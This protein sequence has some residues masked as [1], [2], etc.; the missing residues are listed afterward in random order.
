VCVKRHTAAVGAVGSALA[1]NEEVPDERNRSSTRSNTRRHSWLAAITQ[2]YWGGL[3]ATDAVV[4]RLFPFLW[5]PR[6]MSTTQFSLMLS[7]NIGAGILVGEYLGGFLSDRFGRKKILVASAI[8]D[9]AFLWPLGYTNSFGWLLLWNFL[10][11]TG[12]GFMLASNAV[13]LH[14]IAP[15]N[16]R[17]RIAMR[18][19]LL[20]AVVI[21]VPAV[22]AYF[23][24]PS[25]YRWY[26]WGLVAI[27][28][29]ILTP[30][31]IFGLPE[32]P[33]WLEGKGR[34]AEADRI[35]SRWEAEI[36][37]LRGPLPPPDAQAHP[38]VETEQ[39]PA[40]ELVSPRYRRR[41][42]LLLAVWLLAYPGL[43]Y[44]ATAYTP[45]YLVEHGWTSHQIFLWGGSGSIIGVPVIIAVFYLCS[46]F[47]E[48]YERK[49]IVTIAGIAFAAALLLLLAFD[50]TKAAVS[51]L[52]LIAGAFGTLWLFN[53]Y[54][55]TAAAYP[56]RLRSVGTGWTDGVGHLGVFLGPPLIGVL[57]TS[58]AP[59]N[60]GWILWCALPCALLPSLIV[61]VFGMRQRNAVLEQIST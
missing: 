8:L 11:A 48:R 30:L 33:R 32:S 4:A 21:A 39:V 45:T 46:L 6:G 9:A 47:G 42:I 12:M 36:T 51:V 20:T 28:I 40:K 27:M 50:G 16:F 15:P 38:V 25:H 2:I 13:Y 56:T 19:Q 31:G 17:H 57:F 24:I 43:V 55:Y 53:M 58:T 23:W 61:G 26:L 37:R 54:N 14:E 5:G 35:V 52:L 10:Y 7:A 49:Y 44:G 60:Y 22:M 41:T 18:T 34:H 59:S 1:R 3:I 29:L